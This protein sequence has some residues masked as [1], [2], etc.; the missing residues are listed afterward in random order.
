MSNLAKKVGT[1]VAYAMH[2]TQPANRAVIYVRLSKEDIDK[3]KEGDDS[4]SIA[5]QIMLLTNYAI[6]N[7]FQIVDIYKDD[8]YSGMFDDRP[9]FERLVSDAKTGKFDVVISKTQSRFTRNMEH[10]E[11]YLHDF[12]P[13][14]NIRFIGVVDHA[15]TDNKGNKKAR[16]I[17]GLVNEWFCEDLSENIRSVLKVKMEKGQFIGSSAC[18][19]YKKDPQNHNHLVIDEYASEIV[20]KIYKMF[21]SGDSKH[22]IARTLDEECILIPSKYKAANGSTY[23]NP[24]VRPDSKW[25][26][27][28][29]HTILS[30]E[31]YTGAVVQN[32][33]NVVS[34]KSRAKRVLP[35]D[36]WVIVPDMHE[37]IISKE[38]WELVQE[39]L[40]ERTRVVD[41]TQKAG[42]FSGK[43]TCGECGR[44]LT[45]KYTRGSKTN[46]K[47]FIGYQCSQYKC[48]GRAGCTGHW[49]EDEA[50]QEIVLLQIKQAAK[51]FLN[52]D[53]IE[54]LN[55]L[56]AESDLIESLTKQIS[57]IKPQLN[58]I[59]VY[60][61]KVYQN[62]LDEILTKE[63]YLQYKA[64]YQNE[65]DTK[66]QVISNLEK[67][68]E[69]AANKKQSKDMWAEKFKNYIDIDELDRNVVVEL[70]H[71]IEF[72]NDNTVRILFRFQ[73]E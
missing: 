39:L 23:V 20:K 22:K 6:S 68:I 1:A 65:L 10:M 59:E 7:G 19:G 17:N 16:Q 21:I 36:Q 45:R 47:R 42:I 28:T 27:T 71:K 38:T 60:L 49:I 2:A 56:S 48:Y 73:E 63:E 53:D 50:L 37:P 31:T 29:I 70:V 58:K 35:K 61:K 72:S 15:D 4:A 44:P 8:D 62:Y 12:F 33:V 41:M 43:L 54:E 24:Q 52:K 66:R 30:N 67:Q 3:L 57:V 5:N 26:H 51:Q 13:T 11:R 55:A 18:Y 46:P 64:E 40:K 25:T 32:R 14:L 9:D 34:Y 69:L